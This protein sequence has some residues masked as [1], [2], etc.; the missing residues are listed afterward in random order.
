MTERAD[1]ASFLRLRRA[2]LTP[3]QCGLPVGPRRRTP[4]LRREELAQLAGISA[5]WYAWIE[6]GRNV[7]V[8]P[9]ALARLADALRLAR[10]ERAYLFA[11]AGKRDPSELSTETA[12]DPPAILA[13][14]VA[15]I[16]TPA[17]VLDRL[18]TALLWNR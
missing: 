14:A 13:P 18:G 12:T 9:A 15:A 11:L 7:S 6:Q 8:S 17:Y 5:T 16:A 4:G 1:L 2:R 3:R 10:A